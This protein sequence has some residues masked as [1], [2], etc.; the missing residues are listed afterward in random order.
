MRIPVSWLREHVPFE[1]EVSRL[2]GDLTA[3]GLA[4]DAVEAVGAEQVLDLDV[5]TNRVDCMNVYGVAR[6]VSAL[7]G[8]PL[9]PLDTSVSE[10]GEEAAG[11]LQVEIEAPDLCGRFCARVLEVT[12]GPSPSWLRDR[13]ELVGIRSI[14]NLVDLTNYVMVEMGQPSH[15]F[16]LARVPGATLV[17]RWSR[18]GEALATLDGVT[19]R[20]PARVGVIAGGGGQTALALAGVMGGASSEIGDDT[21]LVALEAAW[22]EPLAVRR[23]SRAMGMHTEASHRFERGAD[24]ASGGPPALDRLAH[25]LVRAGAGRARP[26]TIERRGGMPPGRT[27]RFRPAKVGALL[28]AEVPRLQQVRTLESLG[29]I[30][31]GSAPEAAAHVP[32]WRLDVSGRPTSPRRWGA[33]SA[34]AASPPSSR[35]RRGGG[36][37][38]GRSGASGAFARCSRGWGWSRSSTTPSWPAR[39]WTSP[40]GRGRLS[41]TRSP[42]SRTPFGPRWWCRASSTRC[43]RTCGWAGGTWRCSSWGGC[44]CAR[45]RLLARCG[46]WPC[47]SRGA[48][49]RTTGRC[50][51]GP[52]TSSTSRDR[53]AALRAAGRARPRDRPGGAPP[54]VPAPGT[55]GEPAAR[56]G[57][58][59]GYAGSVHP[60]A[61]AAWELKDEAVVMEI[62]IGELLEGP[63]RV[64]RFSAFARFPAVQRDLSILC[65]EGTP[66]AE[67]DARVRAAAGERLRSVSLLDRYTGNQVPAGKVSLTV[68][69]RFQDSERT[70]TSDEVQEAVDGVVRELRAAGLEIRGE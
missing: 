44:S 39:G 23:G 12:V 20:L 25:L 2:A 56:R 5:T 11:A 8:L 38:A 13:L 49:T 9:R 55:G 47:C 42:R 37:C 10:A 29:F 60:D 41:R 14:N 32:S 4:V 64:A 15:A 69:L 18:E 3:V 17:V 70:L 43:A 31:S 48:R 28:G 22:W 1:V 16:D 21:R 65:D 68:S 19:R 61:R 7:Y 24:V 35:P 33:T 51:R 45:R 6:E 54:A 59:I 52:S 46:G 30:V 67:I 53:R 58:R 50:G 36:G 40:R 62:D 27:V 63:P 34:S 57:R 26:G 66:A